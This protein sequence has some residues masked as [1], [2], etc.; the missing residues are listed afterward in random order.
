[1]SRESASTARFAGRACETDDLLLQ[2]DAVQELDDQ[3]EAKLLGDLIG[4]HRGR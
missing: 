1:M 2:H 3:R 4:R